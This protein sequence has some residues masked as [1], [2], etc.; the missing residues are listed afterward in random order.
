MIAS[1]KDYKISTIFFFLIA[2]PISL[3]SQDFCLES[4]RNLDFYQGV[5]N[6]LTVNVPNTP[7]DSICV[8]S[9]NGTIRKL[10][11]CR[12]LYL[13]ETLG[14]SILTI[15]KISKNDTIVIG[16]RNCQ[17]KDLPKPTAR[18]AGK[19]NGDIEKNLLLA[20]IGIASA[21]ENFGFDLSIRVI[22]FRTIIIRGD[23]IL[24]NSINEGYKF[25]AETK[26][27]LKK[28]DSGDIV[29]FVSIKCIFPSGNTTTAN[30]IELKIK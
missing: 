26:S 12:Y 20:Q 6:P 2:F 25:T 1:I 5:D 7:C 9:D 10:D 8:S 17:I 27:G 28:I 21:M 3:F 24:F 15:N 14:E 13:P 29:Y 11:E 23:N 16:E 30:S 4:S 19:I 18:V 22:E